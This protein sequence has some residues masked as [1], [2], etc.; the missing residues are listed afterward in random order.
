M[1]LLNFR[2]LEITRILPLLAITGM[3]K[4][5]GA[6]MVNELNIV[7]SQDRDAFSQ[8]LKVRRA[9]FV[10]EQRIPRHLDFD[11]YDQ[12][13]WHILAKSNQGDLMG[14]ARITPHDGMAILAR[15]AVVKAFR[16]KGIASVL[17]N[18]AL[19]LA[20]KLKLT[21]V[22]IHAHEYLFN[23]YRQFGFEYIK[24][25]EVVGGHQLIAMEKA[26]S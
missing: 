7:S 21:K 19:T 2:E 26:I 4:K 14:C 11:G 12:Y 3:A 22:E 15:I 1:Y 23:Y 5:N 24:P 18:E 10:V 6:S 20:S 16:G 25:V 13:S 8:A 9:V 17:V